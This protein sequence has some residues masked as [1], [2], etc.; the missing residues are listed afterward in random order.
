[1]G[2][3]NLTIF[4]YVIMGCSNH[5]SPPESFITLES[6]YSQNFV[7]KFSLLQFLYYSERPVNWLICCCDFPGMEFWLSTG[8]KSIGAC[9]KWSQGW[10][11]TASRGTTV[12][13]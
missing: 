5:W 3:L 13:Y 8:G 12:I 7:S 6:R 2:S 4:C 9:G 1:M 10:T 11:R